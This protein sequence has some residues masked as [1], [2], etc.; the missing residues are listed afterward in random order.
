M[1]IVLL[2]PPVIEDRRC[3]VFPGIGAN[4]SYIDNFCVRLEEPMPVNF[5]GA[6]GV[7][8]T[9]DPRASTPITS[10]FGLVSRKKRPIPARVP[11]VDTGTNTASTLPFI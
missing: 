10:V 9:T 5:R 3:I 2:Q 6:G 11:P 7:P 4:T 1:Q 8:K